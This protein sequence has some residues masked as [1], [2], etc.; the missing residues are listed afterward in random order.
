MVAF[1]SHAWKIFIMPGFFSCHPSQ[2][3]YDMNLGLFLKTDCVS[4][5]LMSHEYLH[6]IRQPVFLPLLRQQQSL[7]C[8]TPIEC[9][10][11]GFVILLFFSH[12]VVSSPFWTRGLHAARQT[13]L[14]LTSPRVCPSPCSLHRWCHPISSSDALFSCPQSFP[15]SVTFPHRLSASDD[16]NTGAS[17]SASVHPLNIQGWSSLRLP[18]LISLLS[19]GTF[20]SLLQHHSSKASILWPSAFF[21]VQLS[22]PNMTTRKTIVLTIRTFVG[23]VVP[24][25]FNTLLNLG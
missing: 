16:Q 7:C 21:T 13:S 15:A 22:Q 25:L 17:A 9:P 6:A 18:G 19:Q 11:L 23:R 1:Y 8:L 3:R 4:V 12:P 24:L 20:R 2:I 14:S 5:Q 10:Q